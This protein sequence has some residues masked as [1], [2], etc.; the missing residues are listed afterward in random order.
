MAEGENQS[1][2]SSN[3]RTDGKVKVRISNSPRND[4]LGKVMEYGEAESVLILS[5]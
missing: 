2:R 3:G 5:V 4:R 1:S